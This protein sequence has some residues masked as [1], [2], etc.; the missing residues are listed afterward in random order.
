MKFYPHGIGRER[1]AVTYDTVK[2]H[3]VSYVQKT[4]KNGQDTAVSLRDLRKKDLNLLQPKRGAS[5]AVDSTEQQQEQAGM[6]IMYQAELERYLDRKDTLET[7]LTKAY[8]LIF[9]AYCNKTMQN[10]IEEHP[11]YESTI[12]DDP[13]EL[14]TKIKVLMHDPIRAKYPFA[15]LTEAMSRML[16]LKQIENEGL[17]DYVKRFKESCD[18]TKSHVGTDILDKFVENTIEYREETDATLQQEMKDGAFDKWMAYLLIRNS[19]QAKYG[20]MMNGLVS[21]FSLQNNQYPKTCTTATDILSSH[22][23]DNRGTTN[24][25]KW[26]KPKNNED[27]NASTQRTSEANETSFAQG[28]SDKS[29]YCCGKKGHLSPD[30]PQKNSIKKEDW[31]IRKSQTVYVQNEKQDDHQDDDSVGDNVSTISRGSSKTIGWSALLIKQ[32]ESLYTEDR[33]IVSRMK[34]CITLDTGSTLSIFSNPALVEGIRTSET[35]L[36][37]NTN[38]GVS[39][40]NQEAIVPSFGKV[41]YDANAIA[42]IFG[43]SDLKKKHRITYDSD[44]EDAFSVYMNDGVVKFECSPDGLYQF[45]VSKQ[46]RD[47]LIKDQEQEG[48]SNLIST[49]AENRAGYTQRQYE[50]AKEARRLYHIVGTPTVENFKS[51]LRMNVIKNCPVTTEDVNIA[52]KIFGKDISSL[53]GKSTRRKPKPVRADLIEIPKELIEKHHEVELCMDTMYVNEC[54]MLTAIDKSLKFRSLV[55]RNTKQHLSFIPIYRCGR[56]G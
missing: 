40:S 9:S 32:K 3:I 46:Y 15:S 14:L 17:L 31:A 21:Q 33:E 49:V 19:D 2:D 51:L 23:L 45:K 28:N 41:Y 25:K 29:C 26:S 55:L 34:N 36:A 50:R 13:I 48:T 43:F 16:N 10:R 27:E 35:T 5:V 4:Y 22:R 8:A 37:L 56:R 52:E 44:K 6:D 1:Q 54:G 24:K 18:I 7:N 11:D 20:S 12:R 42:N 38:A 39:H 30:C 53:K 47:T